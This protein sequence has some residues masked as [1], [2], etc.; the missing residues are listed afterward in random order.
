MTN[1]RLSLELLRAF[2]EVYPCHASEDNLKLLRAAREDLEHLRKL[3][4][5]Q[6]LIE[7]ISDDVTVDV[8]RETWEK[9]KEGTYDVY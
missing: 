9:I 3:L 1:I 4:I 8:L 7:G 5:L 6:G 2:L